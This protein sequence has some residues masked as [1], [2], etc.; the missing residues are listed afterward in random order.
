MFD[1]EWII[2]LPHY[3]YGVTLFGMLAVL[4]ALVSGNM[5]IHEVGRLLAGHEEADWKAVLMNLGVLVASVML[6]VLAAWQ[7]I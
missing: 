3:R 2:N 7:W 4:P 6:M 5:L 1:W